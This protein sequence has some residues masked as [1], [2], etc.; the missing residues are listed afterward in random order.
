MKR[1]ALFAL[2]LAMSMPTYAATTIILVRHAEKAVMQGDMP[3]SEAGA[4][5]AKELARVLADAR[6]SAIYTTQYRRTKET[7]APLAEALKLTPKEI[8]TGGKEYAGTVVREVLA[9]HKGETVVVAGHSNT[10]VD[11]LRELG[12]KDPPFIPEPQFDD[13]FVCTVGDALPAT[14][15]ALRYGAVTR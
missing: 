10:T 8:V 1:A 11:V 6:V 12:M 3:L 13:L 9:N 2:L 7:V 5:R 14:C 4:A 15:V